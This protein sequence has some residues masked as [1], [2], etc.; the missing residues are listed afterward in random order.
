M[1]DKTIW[2]LKQILPLVY[3]SEYT[4]NNKRQ[5]SIWR[6]WFGRCFCHRKFTLVSES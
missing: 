2:Y 6:M 5:L 4:E 3:I 1:M